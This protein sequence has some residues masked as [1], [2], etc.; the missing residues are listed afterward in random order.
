MNWQTAPKVFNSYF[1][2]SF[3]FTAD[4]LTCF[5]C[6]NREPIT[7]RVCGWKEIWYKLLTS[8][9]FG[10]LI[11]P[12]FNFKLF[13]SSMNL[14]KL[15]TSLCCCVGLNFFFFCWKKLLEM[16]SCFLS[17]ND[18]SLDFCRHRNSWVNCNV[19]K[20]TFFLVVGGN[21]SSSSF[22][23]LLWISKEF[24]LLDEVKLLNVDG[25]NSFSFY[26]RNINFNRTVRWELVNKSFILSNCCILFTFLKTN[27]L[28]EHKYTRKDWDFSCMFC[29][30]FYL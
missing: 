18:A 11:I 3:W 22:T 7:V 19:S 16:Y 4:L 28:K 21:V 15:L 10:H 6:S 17:V 29:A 23:K 13:K 25:W 26:T 12:S 24:S 9:L 30:V 14:V 1:E 27:T 2:V 20:I 8:R 5:R